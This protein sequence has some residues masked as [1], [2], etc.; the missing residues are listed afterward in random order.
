MTKAKK[1][2]TAPKFEKKLSSKVV[3][4]K[5]V[6]S[7][8][9]IAEEGDKALFNI[10]GIATSTETGA[11]DHGPWTA[12]KG[13]FEATNLETGEVFQSAKAFLPSVAQDIVEGQMIS[14]GDGQVEAV[15]FAFEIGIKANDSA[16]GFEYT[17]SS[18]MKVADHNPLE[19]LRQTLIA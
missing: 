3:V 18:L 19:D 12:L 6:K 7:L 9:K 2:N 8:R 14:H 15:R 1:E 11:G 4:D 17:C 13:Q 16:I 10:M 5:D